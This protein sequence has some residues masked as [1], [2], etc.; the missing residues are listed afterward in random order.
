MPEFVLDTVVLQAMSF[1]DPDGIAILFEGLAISKA[2][3]P[4]EVYNQ[5]ER[6]LP[7]DARDREMNRS[8]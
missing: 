1:S 2:R 7:M 4:A 6:T 8:T 5:D 3:F